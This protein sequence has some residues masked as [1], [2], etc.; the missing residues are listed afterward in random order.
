MPFIL[1]VIGPGTCI[2][3]KRYAIIVRR[4]LISYSVISNRD[5]N[6]TAQCLLLLSVVRPS[7]EYGS[8]TWECNKSQGRELDSII[9][10]GAKKILGCSSKMCNEAV[11]GA[12]KL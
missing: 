5:I 11:T 9:L 2:S 8:E 6:L 12:W 4:K 3:I 10:G 7:L 1:H